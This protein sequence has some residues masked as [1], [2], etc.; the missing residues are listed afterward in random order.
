MGRPSGHFNAFP[1][2]LA[3]KHSNII[4]NDKR[5]KLTSRAS[6][7]WKMLS[8]AWNY[9]LRNLRSEMGAYSTFFDSDYD[10]AHAFPCRASLHA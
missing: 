1:H 4:W 10:W 6:V 3:I 7:V 5:G 9:K 2:S 8:A